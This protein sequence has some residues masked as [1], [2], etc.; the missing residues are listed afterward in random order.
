[1]RI[2]TEKY[3]YIDQNVIGDA[4]DGNFTLP[5]S[6]DFDWVYSIEHFNEIKRGGDK[7]FLTV[8][9]EL[10][11]RKLELVLDDNFRITGDAKINQFED[12][13]HLY[14]KYIQTVDEV[15]VDE[16]LFIQP[17]AR[18]LGAD[19]YD[20]LT[21]LPDNLERELTVLLGTAGLLDTE[22]SARIKDTVDA[23]RTLV[24]EYLKDRVPLELARK[25]LGT[26]NGRAGNIAERENPL[27]DLWGLIRD[28]VGTL[29]ADQFFGFDPI[30]KQGYENVPLYLGIVGC[31]TVLNFV[32]LRPDEGLSK[33]KRI[34]AVMSDG[35]HVANA[36][37]CHALIS[38]DRRLCSKARAIYKYKSIGTTVL[39]LA[40]K[41]ELAKPQ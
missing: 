9:S 31:Y 37:Y 16:N 17:L 5:V 22:S 10:K 3:I 28:R 25:G 26:H 29:T 14:E 30:E 21:S 12:P 23:S 40:P 39:H 24:S 41:N 13:H 20:T 32:G 35:A 34:P 33:V 27:E 8:L 18:M 36:A 11:A 6:S 4:S 2:M 7:R 1:M 38:G 15:P 19:N